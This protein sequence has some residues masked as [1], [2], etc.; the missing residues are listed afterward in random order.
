M[1]VNFYL[2][3]PS[4]LLLPSQ[5]ELA[6]SLGLPSHISRHFLPEIKFNLFGCKCFLEYSRRIYLPND[7]DFLPKYFKISELMAIDVSIFRAKHC[8]V[9]R[10]HSINFISLCFNNIFQIFNYKLFS[11]FYF[12]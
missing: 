8:F 9:K 6:D 3:F 1:D 12:G 7:S 2:L 10:A 11:C 5:V 4:L